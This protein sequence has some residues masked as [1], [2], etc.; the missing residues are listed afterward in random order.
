M[1]RLVSSMSDTNLQLQGKLRRAPTMVTDD[2]DDFGDNEEQF[3]S[4]ATVMPGLD[5]DRVKIQFDQDIADAPRLSQK[6]FG[7][8]A[9][10]NRNRM[11]FVTARH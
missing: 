11:A 8:V 1:C 2:E 4:S 7:D 9:D 3:F 5:E 6:E 10:R